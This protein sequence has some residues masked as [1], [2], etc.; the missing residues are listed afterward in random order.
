MNSLLWIVA[1]LGVVCIVL[2]AL[3]LV[4]RLR[5]NALAADLRV[6]RNQKNNLMRENVHLQDDLD[7]SRAQCDVTAQAFTELDSLHQK[8]VAARDILSRECRK[9]EDAIAYY[10]G[11]L[12][13]CQIERD[14]WSKLYNELLTTYHAAQGDA[15]ATVPLQEVAPASVK[16]TRKKAGQG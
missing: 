9:S 5:N 16:R 7:K 4:V 13:Q 14:K 11:E 6:T 12:Q 1:A 2:A 15:H 3:Y 10:V 8:V